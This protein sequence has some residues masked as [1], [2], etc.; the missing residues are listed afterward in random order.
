[1]LVRVA[2]QTA[3]PVLGMTADGAKGVLGGDQTGTDQAREAL[4]SRFRLG[5][6]RIFLRCHMRYA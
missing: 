5:F 4:W 1:M 2:P 6:L 3:H